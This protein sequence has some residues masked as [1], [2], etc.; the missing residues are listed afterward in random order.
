M[1][2]N[3]Q[4]KEAPSGHHSILD[5]NFMKELYRWDTSY[6]YKIK[7]CNL[8]SKSIGLPSL[9]KF[10]ASSIWKELPYIKI[11][12]SK[13]TGLTPRICVLC[14]WTLNVKSKYESCN[15]TQNMWFTN[16]FSNAKHKEF[17]TWLGE[18]IALTNVDSDGL[19]RK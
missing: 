17:P 18:I 7:G 11:Y 5:L 4:K 6:K 2:C 10:R 1:K 12:R 15:S 19:R 8:P 14:L 13:H 16:G 3:F 9:K